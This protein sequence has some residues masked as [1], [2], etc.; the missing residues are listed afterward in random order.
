[1]ENSELR[2]GELAA[3]SGVSI[4]A[5]RYY[6]RLGLL[7]RARRSAGGFR[8]FGRESIE[9]V[10]FIKQAQELGLSLNE[11][12][13]F[14]STGGAAECKRVR[15]LMQTKIE[16]LDIRARAMKEFRRMLGRQLSERDRELEA[17]GAAVCCPV[18]TG[19][20]IPR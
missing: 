17:H 1:M 3:R 7:P 19:S 13:G 12:R 11:I 8:L 14:L 6:E 10:L 9:R 5:L 4:D 20:R 15:D 18:V 2:I 16:E